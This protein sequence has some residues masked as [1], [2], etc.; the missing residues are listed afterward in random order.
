MNES[1]HKEKLSK[2]GE[3]VQNSKNLLEL[4]TN[5]NAYEVAHEQARRNCPKLTTF[6]TVDLEN[7]PSFGGITPP[8]NKEIFSWDEKQFL[9]LSRDETPAS[10]RVITLPVYILENRDAVKGG[11]HKEPPRPASVQFVGEMSAV[12]LDYPDQPGPLVEK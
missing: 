8:D 3:R 10:T 7:L 9:V 2:I 12:Q 11:E 6:H 1:E 4:W 5:L